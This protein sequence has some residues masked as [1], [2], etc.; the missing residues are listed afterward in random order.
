VG[1]RLSRELD[2]GMIHV[3]LMLEPP[4]ITLETQGNPHVPEPDTQSP[5]FAGG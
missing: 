2:H 1:A 3:N 4:V 5:A